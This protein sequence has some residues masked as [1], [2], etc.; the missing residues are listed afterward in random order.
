MIIFEGE[1]RDLFPRDKFTTSTEIL[2]Q[3]FLKNSKGPYQLSDVGAGCRLL[4]AAGNNDDY[5]GSLSIRNI[6]FA[7][8]MNV[9]LYRENDLSQVPKLI[10][11]ILVEFNMGTRRSSPTGR[12]GIEI[13]FSNG[14]VVPSK[15]TDWALKVA[16]QCSTIASE[17]LDSVYNEDSSR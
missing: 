16:R 3:L 13:V 9:T 12:E 10:N 6:S 4:Y 17:H 11:S 15:A 8:G 7:K 2:I 5:Q 1:I 14:L